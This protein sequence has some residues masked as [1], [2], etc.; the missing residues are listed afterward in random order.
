MDDH[1]SQQFTLDC[2]HSAHT[3]ASAVTGASD[4]KSEAHLTK[5]VC[6]GTRPPESGY[7]LIRDDEVT[8]L[9]LRI[10]AGG[11]RAFVYDGR[12]LGRMFRK[13]FGHF[14]EMTVLEA[15]KAAQALRSADRVPER[16][17]G[18]V[19]LGQL[20]D[21][22]LERHAKPHK[23]SWQGDKELWG[24]CVPKSWHAVKLTDVTPSMIAKWHYDLGSSRGE[25]RANRAVALMR[26]LFNRAKDWELFRGENPCRVKLF[27]E[28]PR[29]RFLTPEEV[30]RL[31]E[32][33]MEEPNSLWKVFFPLS[34]YIGTR[35]SELLAARWEHVDFDAMTL[36]F[37]DTKSGESH[38]VPL[39]QAAFDLIKTLPTQDSGWL[40]PSHSRSG[41]L[42]EVKSAWHRITERAGI[43]DARV[44]DLRRTLG[45]WLAGA[46]YG[47]PVIGRALGHST[48]QATSIYAKLDL[49]PVRAA[50]EAN[51]ALLRVAFNRAQEEDADGKA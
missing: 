8:G 4:K 49:A 2:T 9:C 40:F 28:R 31:N 48:Q 35:R 6:A 27:K 26:S 17:R 47:L 15:R 16:S 22:Y 32:A 29:K 12:V 36:T 3:D 24:S 20:F 50:L 39:P 23:K 1:S 5:A 10:T 46:G 34:L 7:R 30:R 19:K 14:P 45:S 25:H 13:T 43:K 33:L 38:T 18:G 42:E 44:H 21:Q 37:P 51:A 11:S 41:H